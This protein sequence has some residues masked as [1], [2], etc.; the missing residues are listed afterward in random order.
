MHIER[1]DNMAYYVFIENGKINGCS[2]LNNK[3]F[4]TEN[5]FQIE[6]SEELYNT[7]STEPGK[8]IY[9]AGTNSIVENPEY[10]AEQAAKKEERI[11]M[12]KMT[13]G[14][15]FEYTIVTKGLDESDI[16]AMIE[17]E[18]TLDA[19]TKKLY[20]NRIDNALYFYRGHPAVDFIGNKLGL[21]KEELD[22]L[23]E[24]KNAAE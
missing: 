6:V 13:R 15:L 4:W 8:F 24:E 7:F 22:A 17:Q 1:L 3:R 11:K 16:R 5:Y 2:E 14:D 20:L 9:D 12:L 10:E 23:F 19:V 18:E 21:T